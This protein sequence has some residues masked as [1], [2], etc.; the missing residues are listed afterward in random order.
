MAYRYMWIPLISIHCCKLFGLGTAT[1]LLQ[2]LFHIKIDTTWAGD[3]GTLD[4]RAATRTETWTENGQGIWERKQ[5]IQKKG[6]WELGHGLQEHGIW[7]QGYWERIKRIHH[8]LI[9]VLMSPIWCYLHSPDSILLAPSPCAVHHFLFNLAT[10]RYSQP[11]A[12]YFNSS[13]ILHVTSL[14]F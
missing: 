11:L 1:H 7:V 9:S 2:F 13:L 6:I 10:V 4:K 14:L 5:G 8:F 12:M 3:M